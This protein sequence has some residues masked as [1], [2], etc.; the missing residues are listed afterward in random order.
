LSR[1]NK[2]DLAVVWHIQN[3]IYDI[4]TINIHLSMKGLPLLG[5]T[6]RD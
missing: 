1:S 4:N 2:R 3:K 5:S 6:G